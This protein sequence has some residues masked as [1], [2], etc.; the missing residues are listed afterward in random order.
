VRGLSGFFFNDPDS[1]ETGGDTSTIG[2]EVLLIFRTTGG[3]ELKA[4]VFFFSGAPSSESL[5]SSI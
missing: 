3:F 1:F 5:S 4:V 2:L